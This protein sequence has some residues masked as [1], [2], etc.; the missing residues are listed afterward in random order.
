MIDTIDWVWHCLV[1]AEFWERPPTSEAPLRSRIGMRAL[2]PS[3]VGNC[4]C[5]ALAAARV[6]APQSFL[7]LVGGA[8]ALP[9]LLARAEGAARGAAMA[10]GDYQELREA[11]SLGDGGPLRERGV[12]AEAR[13]RTYPA[14]GEPTAPLLSVAPMMDWTDI[15]YR[16]V[17]TPLELSRAR[18]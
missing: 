15:H 7:S 17:T 9:S 12:R 16:C 13:E 11:G 4:R 14:V 2:L 1:D 8:R 3:V 18:G 5:S 6:G 10:V